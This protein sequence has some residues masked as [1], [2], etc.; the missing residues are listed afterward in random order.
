[1]ATGSD[2]VWP[3][4]T[5][6]WS[7]MVLKGRTIVKCNWSD[8]FA[9]LLAKAGG[10]FSTEVISQ[11]E[12]LDTMHERLDTTHERLDTTH[13]VPLDAPVKL[14]ETYGCL[15]VCY[16]LLNPSKTSYL[17]FETLDGK[18]PSDN[19]RPSSTPSSSTEAAQANN[20]SV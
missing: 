17:P 7:S 11:N 13:M 15:Y 1:M 9:T 2:F 5:V 3:S 19:D 10:E 8:N 18:E 12:R 4:V 20:T 16:C 6:K 14:L